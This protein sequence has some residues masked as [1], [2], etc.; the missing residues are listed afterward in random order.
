MTQGELTTKIFT[1]NF[2]LI[3]E[4]INNSNFPNTFKLLLRFDEK[5]KFLTS[6]L[7][8]CQETNNF[9]SSQV[10]TRV[11]IEHFIVAYY[12]WTKAR[13]SETDECATEYYSF[14][15]LQELMKQDNYNAKLDKTYDQGKTPLQNVANKDPEVFGD[16]TEADILDLN[17]RA[18][19]F[20]I[21]KILTYLSDELSP[22]DEFKPIHTVILD[23]CRSYNILST[24]IHGGPTA[25]FKTFDNKPITNFSDVIKSNLENGEMINYQIKA[26]IMLLLIVVDKKYYDIY[27]PIINFINEK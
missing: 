23:Y 1:E 19:Q 25:E 8:T 18:N 26:F 3:Q 5:V 9:Y 4:R 12:V 2:P 17:K 6:L 14:Y 21:R 7:F 20:D 16:I 13:T 22:E 27:E 24:Y 11:I 15:G 10:L